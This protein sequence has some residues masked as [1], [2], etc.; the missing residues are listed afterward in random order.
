LAKEEHVPAKPSAYQQRI[1]IL[2][3]QAEEG[4]KSA[5][6]ELHHR[7]HINKI[8]INGELLDLKERFVESPKGF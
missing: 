4:D 7:Y 1:K 3:R 6:K 2:R 8:F 5:L